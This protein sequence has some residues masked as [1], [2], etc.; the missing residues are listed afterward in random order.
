MVLITNGKKEAR[1]LKR[2]K[3]RFPLAALRGLDTSQ[4][5]TSKDRGSEETMAREILSSRNLPDAHVR[6]SDKCQAETSFAQVQ[7]KQ[8]AG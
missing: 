7:T 5:L 6:L 4:T 2:S 8:P 1:Q 3:R